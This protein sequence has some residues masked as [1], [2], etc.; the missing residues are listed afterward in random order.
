[1]N[2]SHAILTPAGLVHTWGEHF[3]CIEVDY[4]A[5][6]TIERMMNLA[7]PARF[8]HLWVPASMGL[9][10]IKEQIQDMIDDPAWDLGPAGK[11][12]NVAKSGRWKGYISSVTGRRLKPR[13]TTN[14]R[15]IFLEQ[16]GWNFGSSTPEELLKTFQLIEERLGVPMSGSPTSVGLRYLEKLNARYY[17]RY[18][19][20]DPDVDWEA[21]K[22]SHVPAIAWFPAADQAELF[23]EKQTEYLY[24]VDRNGSHPFAASQENMGIGSP[25]HQ[26]GGEFNKKLPGLWDVE[27]SG[28]LSDRLPPLLPKAKHWLPT[29]LLRIVA[30]A[31]C[32]IKVNQAI[33][34]DKGAPVFERW[35]KDLWAFREEYPDGSAERQSVKSIMNNVVGST[36]LGE[37]MDSTL[38]PDWYAQV[39]GSERGVVWY[40]ASKIAKDHGVYP[41]GCYADALYYRSI[42]KDPR[43]A[44]PGVFDHEHS[45]GGYKLAWTL[46]I[47]PDA[48]QV[49]AN[50]KLSASNRI[51]ALKKLLVK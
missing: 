21:M 39:I 6:H 10:F 49:L 3:A 35:A 1:M 34:W 19:E 23:S 36:R 45:L 16:S 9:R 41:V 27:I 18:F 38:R 24:C 51:A 15:I 43:K 11:M 4:S 12:I 22:T 20:K 28:Q 46:E 17:E 8:T 7:L 29:P 30:G 2:T 37:D 32:T 44:I 48:I 47:S 42:E 13:P 33:I 40:K 50:T 14:T 5:G 26:V 31:G 25:V